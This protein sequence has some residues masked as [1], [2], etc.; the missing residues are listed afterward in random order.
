MRLDPLIFSAYP[1]FVIGTE[2]HFR[3]TLGPAGAEVLVKVIADSVTSA[4]GIA[5]KNGF[6]EARTTPTVAYDLA[7]TALNTKFEGVPGVRFVCRNSQNFWILDETYALRV[8]KLDRQ[9]RPTN[10]ESVQ[11]RAISAQQP[12]DDDM[13]DLVHVT[14]GAR[15]ST[16]TGLAEDFVVVRHY[17]GHTNKLQVEWVVDLR[18]LASGQMSPL[19][20]IL[21]IVPVAPVAPAAIV[22]RS[23]KAK[24]TGET[25]E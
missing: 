10:H 16:T 11:Q 13:G 23:Q 8:K 20:P 18:E 25:S 2:D 15:F 6:T 19:A 22:R 21:P 14:A 4:A 7:K 24:E 9:F 3:R 1:I 12:L 17:P 5:A